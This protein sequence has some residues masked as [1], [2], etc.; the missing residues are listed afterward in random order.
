M[1][2]QKSCGRKFGRCNRNL[3]N[4]TPRMLALPSPSKTCPTISGTPTSG[5][6][7]TLHKGLGL[8]HTLVLDF[9]IQTLES[10]CAALKAEA[11]RSH[12]ELAEY[13]QLPS[14]PAHFP[15]AS[16]TTVS[17]FADPCGVGMEVG[18]NENGVV[19]VKSLIPDMSAHLSQVFSLVSVCPCNPPV[20]D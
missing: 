5:E 2:G 14:R 15:L 20:S 1:F 10:E 3:P 16:F 12:R 6:D 9:R 7:C 17:H 8:L 18:L 4:S 13:Y 11:E 19:C